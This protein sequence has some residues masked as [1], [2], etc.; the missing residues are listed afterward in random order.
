MLANPAFV[1][2]FIWLI[3]LFLYTRYWSN[4]FLIL[5]D[6]TF[7]YILLA[8]FVSLFSWLFFIVINKSKSIEFKRKI[9]KFTYNS[10]RKIILFFNIWIIGTVIELIYFRDLPI[11]SLFGLSN[12]SY[13][14]FGLPT[15]HGFLNAIILSISM[16]MLYKYILTDKKVF[17]IY[18]LAT[19]FVPIAGMNRGM[20]TSLLLQSLFVILVFKGIKLKSLLKICFYIVVFVFLFGMLGELRYQGNPDDLYTVFQI[21]ENFPTFLPKSVMW[22]YMYITSSINNIENMIYQFEDFNFQPYIVIFGLIPSVIRVHLDLPIQ[23]NLVDVAFNVTSFMPNYLGAFGI[24]G[25]LFFYF[26]ASMI[27]MAVYYR[28]INRYELRF[29]FTL[30]IL[31]HSIVLSIFSDFFAIQ[32]YVFQILIQ[33]I[34]FSKININNK[35]VGNV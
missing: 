34:I 29:G 25:S 19:L 7:Y 5:S 28:Y 9:F 3:A 32:V 15:L 13:H 21:S 6:K 16:Y 35:G 30:I 33:F 18:Y 31:L 10:E 14:D 12:M 11:L 8:V 4:I 17:L 27:A 24:Y 1:F 23:Q 2:S 22:V 20:L 26:F